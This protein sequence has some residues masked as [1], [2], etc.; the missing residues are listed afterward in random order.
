MIYT[1]GYAGVPVEDIAAFVAHQQALLCDIRFSPHS[2]NPQY[3]QR[4]LQARF[5]ECYQHVPALG[6]RH[7]RGGE[8]S[9]VDYAQGER[10]IATYL[11]DWFA[12]VLLC[13]C[14]DVQTCHRKRVAERLSLRLGYGCLHHRIGPQAATA[15]QMPL[16][17]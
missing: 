8:I 13:V 16:P 17:F 1:I 2:R 4:Q 15:S 12:V 6:N 9:I 3:T 11:Q 14:A 5:G 10:E 7:Y